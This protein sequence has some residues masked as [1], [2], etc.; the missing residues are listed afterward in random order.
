VSTSLCNPDQHECCCCAVISDQSG[1]ITKIWCSRT[2]LIF[3]R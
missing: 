1:L 3:I 2:T